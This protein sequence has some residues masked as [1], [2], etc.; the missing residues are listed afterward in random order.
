MC[1]HIIESLCIYMC[2]YIRMSV[3]IGTH[4]QAIVQCYLNSGHEFLIKTED[5]TQSRD[6]KQRGLRSKGPKVK[7][8]DGMILITQS[9]HITWV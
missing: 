9:M 6:V 3:C 8:S 5:L 1:I 7:K 4:V 2:I